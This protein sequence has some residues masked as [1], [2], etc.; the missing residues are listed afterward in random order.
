M[1]IFTFLSKFEEACKHHFNTFM[2]YVK[3]QQQLG[4]QK[5]N[6]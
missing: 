6:K 1:L 3:Q 4:W 2:F 5:H